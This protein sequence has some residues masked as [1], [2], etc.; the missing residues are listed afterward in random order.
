[1]ANPTGN[2]NANKH[3]NVWVSPLVPVAPR[4]IRDYDIPHSTRLRTSIYFPT[5][6]V[7]NFEMKPMVIQM[8]KVNPFSSFSHKDP[9]Q[10]LRKFMKLCNTVRSNGVSVEAVK[11][12]LF[13]FSLSRRDTDWLDGLLNESI[14]T[15]D[16]VVKR[17]RGSVRGN[18]DATT[19][20][21]VLSKSLEEATKIVKDMAENN[22]QW[23]SS[24]TSASQKKQISVEV[25]A[26]NSL[27]TEMSTLRRNMNEK[28][29]INQKKSI[30]GFFINVEIIIILGSV[31][32]SQ[33]WEHCKAIA[34][35]SG[36]ELP[37]TSHSIEVNEKNQLPIPPVSKSS[38][39]LE[40][41]SKEHI[42]H[43]TKVKLLSKEVIKLESSLPPFLRRLQKNKLDKKFQKI[44]EVFLKQDGS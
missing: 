35:R 25:D 36:R 8:V 43:E 11:L 17:S 21:E 32:L 20:G 30:Y 4:S 19:I 29:K 12:R 10:H 33:N 41:S 28:I 23:I 2:N 16:Q 9:H 3:L 15:W 37:N 7:N 44:L 6:E 24:R 18:L 27:I 13:R 40:E 14:T 1:M 39:E 42:H 34:F 22:P 31:Q 5:M 26:M 38:N